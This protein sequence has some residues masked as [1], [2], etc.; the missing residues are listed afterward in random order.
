[1]HVCLFCELPIVYVR[2]SGVKAPVSHT[3]VLCGPNLFFVP[4]VYT[5]PS[6]RNPMHAT[7]L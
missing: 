2:R 4:G 6:E 7:G 3:R 1:M 5:A